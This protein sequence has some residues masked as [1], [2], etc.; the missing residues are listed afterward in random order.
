MKRL[1]KDYSKEDEIT[2][3][4]ASE[5]YE[6]A[7]RWLK[8][9]FRIL[10]NR[11]I[12]ETTTSGVLNQEALVHLSN[13]ESSAFFDEKTWTRLSEI[14]KS[15][16]SNSAKCLLAG[17][18]TPAA[19]IALRGAEATVKKYCEFKTCDSAEKKQWG[20]IVRELKTRATELNIK[21]TFLGFLDYIR[22][23]KRNFAAHP[24]KI[25]TQREAELVFMQVMNLV[26]D[27]YTE[28]IQ[29]SE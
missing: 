4:D 5:L 16:F 13:E 6:D 2:D 28:I 14:E 25:Y 24:N 29:T 22:D 11:N 19:I 20:P 3:D 18:P 27:T 10:A 1:D 12:L 21:A 7:K 9:M 8:E 26:Q 15:D 17:I 23:A